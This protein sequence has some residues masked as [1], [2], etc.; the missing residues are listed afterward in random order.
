MVLREYTISDY[1]FFEV[2]NIAFRNSNYTY[3]A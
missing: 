2:I 3:F 1:I